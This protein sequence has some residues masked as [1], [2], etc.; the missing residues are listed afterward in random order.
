MA[1]GRIGIDLS[2]RRLAGRQGLAEDLREL[3]AAGPD[4]VEIAPHGLGVILGGRLNEERTDE[5]EEVLAAASHAYTVHAPHAL[6]LMDW[7]RTACSATCWS[8]AYGSRPGS[9]HR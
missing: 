6:D 4:F 2:Q 8:R 1:F 5:V 9:G 7:I 3:E